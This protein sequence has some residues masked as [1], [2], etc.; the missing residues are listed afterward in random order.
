MGHHRP[1]DLAH[2]P[3][4]SDSLRNIQPTCVA[5]ISVASKGPLALLRPAFLLTKPVSTQE[6]P[7]ASVIRLP[8][9]RLQWNETIE[10]LI[11]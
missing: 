9:R 2:L 4:I 11:D 7:N 10:V 8:L 6:L 3:V 1:S 5:V